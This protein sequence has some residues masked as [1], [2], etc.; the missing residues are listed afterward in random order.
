[1]TLLIRERT[2]VAAALC[3]IVGLSLPAAYA[4]QI[5]MKNGDRITGTVKTIIDGKLRIEP[6]YGDEFGVDLA[7]VASVDSDREFEVELADGRQVTAELPG[8]DEEGR[9]ILVV[10][11]VRQTLVLEDIEELKEPE[12]Y[13][14]WDS[15]VDVNATLNKGNTESNSG[16]IYGSSEVK[17]GDHR[18]IGGLTLARE[19]IESVTTKEQTLLVYSY[20]W[21]FREDWFLAGNFSYE[22]DP[23]REL[24][25]RIIVGGGLGHDIWNDAAKLLSIEAGFGYQTQ[26]IENETET[27]SIAYWA[28]RFNHD[29]FGGDLS[30]FHNHNLN[31]ALSG[32]D[33]TVFKSNTGLTYNLT[34]SIYG[35]LQLVYDY[36]SDP[37]DGAENEDLALVV[38]LGIVF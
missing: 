27:G 12:E 36:E 5:V 17:W 23:I 11:G 37:A 18:H 10:N 22:R 30:M 6:G 32:R 31:T 15:R 2:G 24:D 13:F 21:L 26:D 19:E 34:D 16:R 20:N 35:N 7:A 38:G 4:E 3:A 1:V 9:Q 14:S 28:L 8:A 29:F 25:Q 33:N